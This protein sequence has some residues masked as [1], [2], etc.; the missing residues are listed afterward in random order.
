MRARSVVVA[1]TMEELDGDDAADEG[2]PGEA[3]EA[4]DGAE[5]F[6]DGVPVRGAEFAAGEFAEEGAALALAEVAEGA[7]E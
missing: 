3:G 6:R 4:G 5:G 1:T 7:F 2:E